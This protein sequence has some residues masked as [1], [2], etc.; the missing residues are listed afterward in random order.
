MQ[1]FL[2]VQDKIDAA[3]RRMGKS[4][5][6]LRALPDE[7]IVSLF[8]LVPCWDVERR[9]SVQ[10]EQQWDR[11]LEGN[12][13]YDIA[14]LTAAI[15]YCDVVVT[16]KL[17]THLCNACGVATVYNSQVISSIFEIAPLLEQAAK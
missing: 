8:D 11:E 2:E 14:A 13:V 6:D 3:L 1:L 15:P 12:D 17:W 16:E 10:V 9:L 7:K 5:Q 4:F